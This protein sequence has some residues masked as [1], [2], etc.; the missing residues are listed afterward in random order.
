MSEC[1]TEERLLEMLR[2]PET[3]REGFR[4]LVRTYSKALYWQ[5]RR[6]VVNHKDADDILQEVFI[7]IWQ[8]I[9]S[10]RGEAKLTTWMYRIAYFESLSHAKRQK[11]IAENQIEIT[12][13]NDFLVD[14]VAGDPYFD[15][16]RAEKLLQEAIDKLPPKQKQVFV[17]RY[18]SELSYAEIEE[19]TGTSQGSLKASYHH[20]VEK[21]KKSISAHF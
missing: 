2:S 15:G 21:I 8:G 16:D 13:D 9:E 1:Y 6:I 20:A 19:I 18:F 17:M 14:Q 11:R 5:I 4:E 12:E 7:K 10:F 3:K